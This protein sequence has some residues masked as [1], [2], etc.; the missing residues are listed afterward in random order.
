MKTHNRE[1]RYLLRVAM[2]IFADL[3]A[4]SSW[5]FLP[6]DPM[7]ADADDGIYVGISGMGL[8]YCA[9]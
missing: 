4:Q 2:L 6:L 3:L 1:I 7:L 5:H 8:I 9:L